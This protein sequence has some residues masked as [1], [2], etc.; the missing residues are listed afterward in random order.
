MPSVLAREQDRHP[1]RTMA[2]MLE[3]GPEIARGIDI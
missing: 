1:L 2:R 3:L